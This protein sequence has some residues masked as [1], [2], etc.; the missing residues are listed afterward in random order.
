MAPSHSS[1][2]MTFHIP[3]KYITFVILE[4]LLDWF[5]EFYYMFF[6]W[7]VYNMYCYMKADIALDYLVSFHFI[8][9]EILKP[10]ECSAF[11]LS[12]EKH[13][14]VRTVFSFIFVHNAE[15]I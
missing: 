6:L 11:N 1:F 7:K 10:G 2:R 8:A 15:S 5:Q 12:P 13:L 9:T 3:L 4:V 14:G